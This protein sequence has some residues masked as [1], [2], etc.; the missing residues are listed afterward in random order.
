MIVKDELFD[1]SNCRKI[2]SRE[3]ESIGGVGTGGG[4]RVGGSEK[5]GRGFWAGLG[6]RGEGVMEEF[7]E[8]SIWA[9]G[10]WD[11]VQPVFV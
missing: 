6:R 8:S 7:E 1:E 2:R 5:S 3:I 11:L 9:S 10:V 4:S